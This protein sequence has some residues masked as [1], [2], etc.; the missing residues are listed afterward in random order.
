[1]LNRLRCPREHEGRAEY[2]R[3]QVTAN[4]PEPETTYVLAHWVFAGTG[5]T[6]AERFLATTLEPA[7][8]TEGEPT[9]A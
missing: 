5:L 3:A 4:G 6:P 9:H 1:M 8:G 2:R 7:P